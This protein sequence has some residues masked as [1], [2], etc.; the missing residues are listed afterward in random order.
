M[1]ILLTSTCSYKQS[2]TLKILVT[3]LENRS[4]LPVI[5]QLQEGAS[6]W[7]R[8][9]VGTGP[10]SEDEM[11]PSPLVN[12]TSLL[13]EQKRTNKPRKKVRFLWVP[14]TYFYTCTSDR[15]GLCRWWKQH[16]L[17]FIHKNTCANLLKILYAYDSHVL[18]LLFKYI[19]SFLET[20]EIKSTLF[21][22]MIYDADAR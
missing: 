14:Q 2:V 1:C 7:P 4:P 11:P 8:W 21:L 16:C 10:S 12:T 15:R 6:Q 9:L 18:S 19:D 17:R 13:A 20:S 5:T 3:L 22:S